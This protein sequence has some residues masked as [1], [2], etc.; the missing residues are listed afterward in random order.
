M[1]M[2]NGHRA[3]LRELAAL[4]PRFGDGGGGRKLELLGALE[5]ARLGSAAEVLQL[6]DVLCFLR[7]LPGLGN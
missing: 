4:A 1:I 7:A 3:R 2:A 5:H 6:H